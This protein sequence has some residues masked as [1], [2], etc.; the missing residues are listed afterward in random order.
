VPE[1][2]RGVVTRYG[3]FKKVLKP[4]GPYCIDPCF[5]SVEQTADMRQRYFDLLVRTK[6][7]DDTELKIEIQVQFKILDTPA[8]I[9]DATFKLSNYEEQMSA[10]ILDIVRTSVSKQDMNDVYESK[11]QLAMDIKDALTDAM[12]VYGYEILNTLVTNVEPNSNHV[13]QSMNEKTKAQY[14]LEAAQFSAQADAERVIVHG[15][16][17]KIAQ[18]LL[19]E[20]VSRQRQAIVDG[21]SNSVASFSDKVNDVSPR[22]VL[23]IVI[24]T[25]YFDMM[26][27]IG[28]KRKGGN[29]VFTPAATTQ[30]DLLRNSMV[31]AN[32]K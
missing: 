27:D 28:E 5:E 7:K 8:G 31:Q 1:S 10:F 22:D 11:D 3:A 26:K 14:D 13:K 19:G 30:G 20:G 24:M 25:Q 9:S 2:K 12:K 23:E 16:A 4:G 32:F 21:L 15:E 6:S 18:K 29:V 17:N